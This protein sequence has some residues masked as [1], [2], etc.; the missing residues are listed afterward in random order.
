MSGGF[1]PFPAAAANNKSVSIFILVYTE[2]IYLLQTI[3][4]KKNVFWTARA[5]NNIRL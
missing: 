2:I 3:F 5:F 4:R 1:C